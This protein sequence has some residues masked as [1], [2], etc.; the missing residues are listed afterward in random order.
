MPSSFCAS[1]GMETTRA[2]LNQIIIFAVIDGHIDQKRDSIGKRA[3]DRV[4]RIGKIGGAMR[5]DSECLRGGGEIGRTEIDAVRLDPLPRLTDA[6]QAEAAIREHDD[7]D[8]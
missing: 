4:A 6:D 1:S 8:G 3:L 7:H 2:S 5:R